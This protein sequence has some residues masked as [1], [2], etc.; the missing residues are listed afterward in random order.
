[1]A[2]LFYGRETLRRRTIK[3]CGPLS[4][5]RD[6]FAVVL[7]SLRRRF[8]DGEW[9]D[10]ESLQV[11]DLAQQCGVSA[12]PIREA[13]SRLAGEGLV[14]DL[15]GRGY[16][17]RRLDGVDLLDLYRTQQAMAQMAVARCGS[18]VKLEFRLGPQDFIDDPVR[19][20][21]AF[22]EAFIR[23]AN[24]GFLL[25]EQRRLAD[26]LAPARRLEPQVLAETAEAFAALAHTIE[27]AD[28][29]AVLAALEPLFRR[30]RDAAD[31][32]VASMRLNASRY[33]SHI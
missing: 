16:Q 14:E 28:L 24:A 26:R 2:G 19:T 31:A 18:G 13:L 33:K 25:L 20:W 1:V 22:F 11:G 15:R 3:A 21:E 32:L 5:N 9:V 12:T 17:A 6:Q 23:R 7:A 10:G 30:R 4:L 8:R 29:G 27:A